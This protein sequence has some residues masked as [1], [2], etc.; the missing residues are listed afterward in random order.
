M[1]EKTEE[2]TSGGD[3]GVNRQIEELQAKIADAEKRA[4]DALRKFEMTKN[5]RAEE[6]DKRQKEAEARQAYEEA[7]KLQ[8]EKLAEMQAELEKTR[9]TLSE[10]EQ[11]RPAADA[12]TQ[13]QD[14][15][16]TE[17]LGKL[18]E[19]RREKFTNAPLDLLEE[20]V[21]MI[22]VDGDRGGSHH[23]PPSRPPAVT[24]KKWSEMSEADRAQKARDLPVDELTKLISQG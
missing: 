2:T 15:R 9:A 8:A 7:G 3:A 6:R 1:S 4:E 16:R 20:T 23:S 12:W 13:Y 24:G 14:N 19:D 22:S 18:P 5:E 11:L 21:S 10:L 17:L